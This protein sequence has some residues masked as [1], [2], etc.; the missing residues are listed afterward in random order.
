M[1]LYACIV[2]IDSRQYPTSLSDT[3]IFGKFEK[4][5]EET[6]HH[7]LDDAGLDLVIGRQKRGR[8]LNA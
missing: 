4:S 1:G 3:F 6:V 2:N 5:V 8:W 7:L